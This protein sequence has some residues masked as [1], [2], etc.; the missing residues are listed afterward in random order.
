MCYQAIQ[1]IHEWRTIFGS[2]A[3]SVLMAFFAS[4]PQYDTQAACAE[5]AEYQLQ[6]A[7]FIYKDANNDDQPGAFLLEYI[8][9][10]FAVHVSAIVGMVRVD[11][12]GKIGAP[13]YQTVLALTAAAMSPPIFFLLH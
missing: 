5:Y 2:T 3:I 4:V 10:I 11:A 9:R 7:H 13:G 12:L 8:L 1:R 6:D